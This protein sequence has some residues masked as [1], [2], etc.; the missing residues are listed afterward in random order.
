MVITTIGI[1]I[2]LKEAKMAKTNNKTF[3]LIPFN[4]PSGMVTNA[5]R[6]PMSNQ[7]TNLFIYDTLNQISFFDC[8]IYLLIFI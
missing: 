8:W 6:L 2:G 4:M 7:S 1:I 5:T 3:Q